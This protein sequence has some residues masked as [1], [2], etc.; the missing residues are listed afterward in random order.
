M[1][2]AALHYVFDQACVFK[3]RRYVASARHV[4]VRYTPDYLVNAPRKWLIAVQR[5]RPEGPHMATEV[6]DNCRKRLGR[7]RHGKAALADFKGPGG[8]A[9]TIH[10]EAL[11]PRG[12]NVPARRNQFLPHPQGL[13]DTFPRCLVTQCYTPTWQPSPQGA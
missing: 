8:G 4:A 2:L 1:F 7:H 6:F 12:W 9:Y 10:A 13:T 3:N 11:L 5:D